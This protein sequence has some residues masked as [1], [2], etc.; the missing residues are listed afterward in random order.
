MLHTLAGLV[1]SKSGTEF[2]ARHLHMAISF[3]VPLIPIQLLKN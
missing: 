2:I 1:L 3:L